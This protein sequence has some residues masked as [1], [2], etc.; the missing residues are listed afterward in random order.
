MNESIKNRDG[1]MCVTFPGQPR[2]FVIK[3]YYKT[4]CSQQTQ[5]IYLVYRTFFFAKFTCHIMR[6]K[7][8]ITNKSDGY[9]QEMVYG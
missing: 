5:I 8:G 4:D 7:C 6:D 2:G 1:V 9:M 3:Q